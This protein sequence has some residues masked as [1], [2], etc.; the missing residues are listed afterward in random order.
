M[1]AKPRNLDVSIVEQDRKKGKAN[2]ENGKIIKHRM[3]A[4]K[5]GN[6]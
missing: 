6:S 1:K 2:A 4:K 5:K 3:C